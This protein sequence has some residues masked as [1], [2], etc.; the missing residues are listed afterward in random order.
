MAV[1]IGTMMQS[2]QKG[3]IQVMC[4]RLLSVGSVCGGAGD[5][6]DARGDEQEVREGGAEAGGG[7]GGAR[8]LVRHC[9]LD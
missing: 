7:L 1:A 2:G 3:W 6:G 5:A 4:R 9:G 8:V